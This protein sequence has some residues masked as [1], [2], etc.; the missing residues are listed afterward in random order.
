MDP[1]A[2]S[3][4]IEQAGPMRPRGRRGRRLLNRGVCAFSIASAAVGLLF[5]AW[6]LWTVMHRGAAAIN[7]TF[8]THRLAPPG[9][10]DGGVG[11]AIVGTLLMTL[12]ATLLAVP[13]G[14]LAGVWLSEFGRDSRLA[15]IVRM[16]CNVLMGTPS[17]L[18]GLFIYT[19]IVIQTRP[20]HFSGYAGAIALAILMLPLVARTAE[21]MLRLVPNELRE[22]AMA[23]AMPRWRVTLTI[24]FRSA[25]AGII[26]GIVLAV[27]RVSGETAPLM[28]TAL[29]SNYWPDTMN[30]QMSNLTMTVYQYAK[31]PYPDWQQQ[32]WGA[33]LLI[34]AGVLVTTLGAR[35]ILLTGRGRGARR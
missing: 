10:E 33:A 20:P 19:V 15:G 35:L 11:N 24:L 25:K 13:I 8:F 2:L 6:I 28:F 17:I 16:F 14:L 30:E 4:H 7:W 21:E 27:A 32:A 3:W 12:L 1:K 9:A 31:S 29:N 34:T 26:T 5:L 23:L 22:S 18:I